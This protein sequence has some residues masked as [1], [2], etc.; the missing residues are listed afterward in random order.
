MMSTS[1]IEVGHRLLDREAD[2]RG[3]RLDVHPV[4]VALEAE[5][6]GEVAGDHPLGQEPPAD[7]H[8][9]CEADE[10]HQD[11]ERRELEH[12][13]RL[14]DEF[15]GDVA[16]EDVRCRPD[17]AERPAEHRGV[18]EGDEEFGGGDARASS[19][20]SVTIGM[21]I[22][23]TGVLMIK[24]ASGPVIPTVAP[25]SRVA[26]PRVN[27]AMRAPSRLIAPVDWPPA[28]R[29]YIARMVTVAGEANPCRAVRPST[30]VHGSR[31]TSATTTEMAVTSGG[32]GLG[33][34]QCHRDRDEREDDERLG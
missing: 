16:R 6:G 13:E 11:P 9:V 26:S 8:Q 3:L 18:R 5:L 34:E 12:R 4:E 20:R 17:Q 23:T 2:Q 31:T 29:T 15:V 30:P 33:D 14:A 28:L 25:R 32:D 10:E 27:A 21:N 19:A 7:G 24:P 22:A 1:T